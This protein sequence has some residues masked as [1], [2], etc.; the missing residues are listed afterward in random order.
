MRAI[1]YSEAGGPEELRLVIRPD[2]APGPGEVLVRSAASGVN[3][4]DLKARSAG[5]LGGRGV[6]PDGVVPNQDG[7]GTIE[8]VGPGVDP[9]RVGERVWVWEAAWQRPDGTTQ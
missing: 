9:S 8:A 6:R 3:P 4:S 5:G 1:V 7:A 2:P